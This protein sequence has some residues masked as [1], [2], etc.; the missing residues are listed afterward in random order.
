MLPH[1]RAKKAGRKCKGIS[2]LPL[3]AIALLCLVAGQLIYAGAAAAIQMQFQRP[4]VAGNYIV[5]EWPDPSSP[6]TIPGPGG[7]PVN[8]LGFDPGEQVRITAFAAANQVFT[9]WNSIP[10]LPGAANENTKVFTHDGATV[11]NVTAVFSPGPTRALGLKVNNIFGTNRVE[12]QWNNITVVCTADCTASPY[13]VPDGTSVTVTA[14][15]DAPNGYLFL[16]W[17][18]TVSG[19]VNPY[20]I[21]M[22]ANQNFEANYNWGAPVVHTFSTVGSGSGAIRL[23]PRAGWYGG[24]LIRG[25]MQIAMW[26]NQNLGLEALPDAGSLFIGWEADAAAGG[27]TNPYTFA[28]GNTDKVVDAR[29]DPIAT[30]P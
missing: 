12:A 6:A 18:G 21:V 8:L 20:A 3:L 19:E 7:P 27:T 28:G 30:A 25:T 13:H 15:A 26:N 22:N 23:L 9:T 11:Y 1:I 16:N 5:V 14:Y 17:S 29:F 10:P 24:A 2:H 4:T